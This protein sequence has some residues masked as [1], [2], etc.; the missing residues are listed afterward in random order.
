[1]PLPTMSPMTSPSRCSPRSG[2]RESLATRRVWTHARWR[3]P[4]CASV[5][6]AEER[7]APAPAWRSPARG[8]ARCSASCFSVAARRCA[9]TARLTSSKLAKDN[10]LP[11]DVLESREDAA[12]RGLVTPGC[13]G[14][15]RRIGRIARPVVYD[16][17][18]TWR[19]SEANAPPPP[20]GC[21]WRVNP[22]SRHHLCRAA[23][24]PAFGES[25]SC[26][27]RRHTA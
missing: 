6:A 21:R 16:A 4:A 26:C 13:R 19:V 17:P 5:E 18:E 3:T 12:P 14:H 2:N 10:G 11:I 22:R 7:A 1:M 15:W 8:P 24:E 9:S 27:I 25:R 23:D 20:L